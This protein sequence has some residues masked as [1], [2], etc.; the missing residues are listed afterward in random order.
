[1]KRKT[2]KSNLAKLMYPAAVVGGFIYMWLAG[3]FHLA[4]VESAVGTLGYGYGL[5]NE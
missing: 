4:I 5:A 1:M 3:E 2:R